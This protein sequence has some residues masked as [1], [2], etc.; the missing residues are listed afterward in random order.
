MHR[1][2]PLLYFLCT[3][4]VRSFFHGTCLKK[5]PP[6]GV[7]V[8]SQ[9]SYL[10]LSCDGKV[11]V[12]GAKVKVSKHISNNNNNNT[13]EQSSSETRTTATMTRSNKVLIKADVNTM[14]D[15]PRGEEVQNGTDRHL[16]SPVHEVVQTSS[17]TGKTEVV[18]KNKVTRGLK[19][20]WKLNGKTVGRGH[21]DW[22]GFTVGRG[23]T[24]LSVSSVRLKD[25]G[26]YSCLQ[27]GRERFSLKVIVADPPES[28]S[29]SC[30]KKSP[31][32]KIRCEWTPEKPLILQPDCY[33]LLGKRPSDT[34]HRFHCSFSSRWSRCW[35][36][37]DQDE[38]ELRTLH[39]A[40]LCV[41]SM[42]GNA[43]SPILSFF[44]LDI[45]K[46]DP[47]AGVSV[48]Q[49]VGQ[50]TRISVNWNFPASWKSQ[51]N[52]YELIYEL[53]Y[54]PVNS[55]H[56]QVKMI[57]W[58]RS[59]TI[60]DALSGVEYVI[61]IRIKDEFDGLWSDWS[62][63]VYGSSWTDTRTQEPS[64]SL[65]D[66][67]FSEYEE[68]S[69]TEEDPSVEFPGSSV[70]P[71]D[72]PR[73]IL[74]ISCSFAVLA[75]V[76]SAAYVFRHRERCLSKLHVLKVSGHSKSSTQPAPHAPEVRAL[77]TFDPPRSK[78]EKEKEGNE[79]ERSETA[80]R[81]AVHFNNT[82][83]FLIQSMTHK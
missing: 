17:T 60:T 50:E 21:W 70:G 82:H 63:P 31:S 10:V 30:S 71:A 15:T 59:F 52:Y 9:G 44:P 27:R 23:G 57:K 83:Y 42:A 3:T 7:L 79:D 12:D 13:G 48:R 4:P 5:E 40:Y 78:E 75:A 77:M 37:L 72:V 26:N 45:L 34:F 24:P 11:E 51:D 76:I 62:A 19:R 68:S 32:S 1:F 54:Q 2:L 64:L 47:P 55:S 33:I 67:M 80:R 28:P 73:H 61:H 25:S 16:A 56:E 35:C 22:E 58:R 43:T 74:W 46:P 69:G 53:K 49:E 38:D 18:D 29:L 20:K 65:N 66:Y 81:E 6:P 8:L 14:K 39:V 36:A 41:T